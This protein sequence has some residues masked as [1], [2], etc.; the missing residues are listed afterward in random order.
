MVYESFTTERVFTEI[1]T[2]AEARDLLWRS[3]FQGKVFPSPIVTK[4]NLEAPPFGRGLL[5]RAVFYP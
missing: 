1:T 2:E 4:T 5:L 3:R